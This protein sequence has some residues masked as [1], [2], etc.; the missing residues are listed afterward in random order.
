ML[1]TTPYVPYWRLL[2]VW[3]SMDGLVTSAA[4]HDAC[5]IYM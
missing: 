2:P 1:Q 5:A 4:L 3:G